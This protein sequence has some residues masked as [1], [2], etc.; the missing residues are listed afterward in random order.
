MTT[1]EQ[2]LKPT[3]ESSG[4]DP[5]VLSDRNRRQKTIVS[6]TSHVAMVRIGHAIF[7]LLR[8]GGG[9]PFDLRP[10]DAGLVS[11]ARERRA[12]SR[13][14]NHGRSGEASDDQDPPPALQSLHALVSA[15]Q[16]QAV[17]IKCRPKQLGTWLRL[18]QGNSPLVR[19]QPL[20]KGL[21]PGIQRPG[22][23][24]LARAAEQRIEVTFELKHVA[25]II[26]SGEPECPV[27]L[28]RHR[29]VA[30][31]LAQGLRQRNG[32]L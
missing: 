9:R 13:A 2:F 18:R 3:T 5:S 25:Q 23:R 14:E 11:V 24:R 8:M 22:D 19:L 6:L 29:V 4:T 7:I 26:R 28:R 17:S 32:H 10:D 1:P 21:Q 30:H 16:A 27:H 20:R 31:L 12:P 15:F